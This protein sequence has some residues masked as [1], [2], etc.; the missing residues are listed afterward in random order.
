MIAADVHFISARQVIKSPMNRTSTGSPGTASTHSPK[1]YISSRKSSIA[2]TEASTPSDVL[3]RTPSRSS[4]LV[5]EALSP[6]MSERQV[7]DAPTPSKRQRTEDGV[8]KRSAETVCLQPASSGGTNNHISA[9]GFAADVDP[10]IGNTKLTRQY[11]NAFMGRSNGL[12]FEVLPNGPFTEWAMNSRNKSLPDR[13]MLYAVMSL[14]T[15]NSKDSK[16]AEHRA[17]F[18]SIIQSQLDRLETQYC[19]QLAHAFAYLSFAEYADGQHQKGFTC[20]VRYVGVI[21]FL[22]LN[23]EAPF[24]DDSITYGFSRNMYAEC[25]RRTY[26]AAFCMDTFAG[27]SKRSPRILTSNDVYLKLPCASELYEKDQIPNTPMFDQENV[28]PPTITSQDHV[29]LGNLVYLIQIT[30]ICSEVQ[31]NVWRCSNSLRVG[32]PYVTDQTVREKLSNRLENW[33]HT[34]TAALRAKEGETIDSQIPSSQTRDFSGARATKFAGLDILF[35][36]AHMELNRRVY[37]KALTTEEI[38]AHARSASIHAVEVLKL[39]K[40]LLEPGGPETRDYQFVIRGPLPSFAV[41]TAIDILTAAGKT[42]DILEPES[43]IMNLLYHGLEFLEVLSSGWEFAKLRHMQ[44]KERVQAVFISAQAAANQGK[45]Y[46]FCNEPLYSDADKDK[47]LDLIY[48]SDRQVYLQ[49]GYNMNNLVEE[50]EVFKIETRGKQSNP[51]YLGKNSTK[52][53][54]W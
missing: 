30:S 25:R 53:S 41:H 39:S 24:S 14:G 44:C 34:Y 5:D 43:R 15:V 33:A 17:L 54:G 31:R 51:Q 28:L 49:A 19:L 50:D 36:W 3:H 16:A 18:K 6:I 35:H 45:T 46:W 1:E 11:V 2:P 12:T 42:R 8:R 48:G 22:Q 37:H 4:V 20:F 21:S 40:Q 10:A 47:E 32:R 23:I 13:I 26:W 52:G 27:L 9:F 38:V 29:Q 7:S